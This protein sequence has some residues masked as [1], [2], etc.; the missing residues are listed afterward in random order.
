MACCKKACYS[1]AQHSRRFLCGVFCCSPSYCCSCDADSLLHTKQE[2]SG[3]RLTAQVTPAALTKCRLLLTAH[4]HV[5]T[6]SICSFIE[7]QGNPSTLI[8]MPK[9]ALHSPHLRCFHCSCLP[10]PQQ[11]SL[12]SAQIRALSCLIQAARRPCACWRLQQPPWAVLPPALHLLL[13]LAA[14]CVCPYCWGPTKMIKIRLTTFAASAWKWAAAVSV[15]T[16]TAAAASEI[17]R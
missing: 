9:T 10:A 4:C 5:P 7:A 6:S 13:L 14:A 2:G 8:T 12:C 16:A 17:C 1:T 11:L 3:Y 15:E